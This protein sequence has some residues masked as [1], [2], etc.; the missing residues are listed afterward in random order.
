M[1]LL[2]GAGEEEGRGEEERAA[3]EGDGTP[4]GRVAPLVFTPRQSPMSTLS[5]EVCLATIAPVS[6]ASVIRLVTEPAWWE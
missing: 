4:E 1:G 3:H 2:A 6:I 5:L